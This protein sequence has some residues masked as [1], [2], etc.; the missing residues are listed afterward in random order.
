MGFSCAE[1]VA[2]AGFASYIFK[3]LDEGN[4][5]NNGKLLKYGKFGFL[6]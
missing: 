5:R 6:R 1:A 3:I 4:R 2:E